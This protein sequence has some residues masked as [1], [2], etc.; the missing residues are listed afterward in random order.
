[1]PAMTVDGDRGATCVSRWLAV[2]LGLLFAGLP[3][4]PPLA[5]DTAPYGGEGGLDHTDWRSTYA[6]MPHLS[7]GQVVIQGNEHAEFSALALV[8]IGAAKLVDPDAMP[9][10]IDLNASIFRRDELRETPTFAREKGENAIGSTLE[11]RI[12]PPVAS[13]AGLPDFS[14]T[15]YD[16]INKNRLCPLPEGLPQREAMC[17]DYKGWIGAGLNASHFGHQ[18]AETYRHLHAVALDHA[19]RAREMRERLDRWPGALDKWRAAVVEAE[20]LA[21]AYEGIAQ[22]FLADRWA[23]AHMWNR[24]SSGSPEDLPTTDLYTNQLVGYLS[25][26]MHGMESV[27]HIKAGDYLGLKKFQ[28]RAIAEQLRSDPLATPYVTYEKVGEDYR[29]E[30][31]QPAIWKHDDDSKKGY[32]GIGDYGIEALLEGRFGGR[33][34]G[35]VN[36]E[37]LPVGE[38]KQEMLACMQGSWADVIRALGRNQKGTWAALEIPLHK[39]AP[40]IEGRGDECLDTWVTNRSMMLA[41]PFSRPSM[42]SV[43]GRSVIGTAKVGDGVAAGGQSILEGVEWLTDSKLGAKKL[44]IG[45][46]AAAETVRLSA[47][48]WAEGRKRPGGIYLAQGGLGALHLDPKPGLL[49]QFADWISSK[50]AAKPKAVFP[51]GGDFG[52]PTYLEPEDWRELPR[53]D[54]TTGRDRRSIF[55]FFSRAGATVLAEDYAELLAS[56]RG[57]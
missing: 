19:R 16:W 30:D 45:R 39:D 34:Y 23:T 22:H 7:G 8:A 15:L 35:F 20:Y 46:A 53:V 26:L 50:P 33:R 1:M 44:A 56:F 42:W 37:P 38:Q 31:L 13:F 28:G 52:A 21:L 5:W 25:G 3:G 57:S 51:M 4:P 47:L 10:V 48:L 29:I 36:E 9:E 27:L 14:Y 41:W 43:L 18:A 6:Q 55:G 11:H 40:T 2:V 32:P 54:S 17:H 49:K 12:L 24:W